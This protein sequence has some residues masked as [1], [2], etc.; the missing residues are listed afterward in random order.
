MEKEKIKLED[1]VTQ[2]HE[3]KDF[4]K[5]VKLFQEWCLQ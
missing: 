1:I 4:D 2:Y 3:D 5:A